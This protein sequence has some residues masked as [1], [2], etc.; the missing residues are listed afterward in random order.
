MAAVKDV[1]RRLR[2]GHSEVGE[3]SLIEVAVAVFAT[4]I[5]APTF[6]IATAVGWQ[7]LLSVTAQVTVAS[8]GGEVLS[9][10]EQQLNG[11]QPIGYCSD[12]QADPSNLSVGAATDAELVTPVGQCPEPASGPEPSSGSTWTSVSLPSPGASS[13]GSPDLTGVALVVASTTCVGFFSYDYEPVSASDG[14]LQPALGTG[15]ALQPPSLVYLWVCATNCPQGD[16]NSLWVT[17]YPSA[18]T[19]TDPACTTSTTGICQSLGW[20][21]TADTRFIGT[22][23]TPTS[24]LAYQDSTGCMAG[25]TSGQ[26]SSTQV[27]ASNLGSVQVVNVTA[28][29][30]SPGQ[31]QTSSVSVEVT[32]NVYQSESTSSA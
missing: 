30:S 31:T 8:Q 1:V 21:S 29:L 9:T 14:G 28:E 2:S 24:V 10:V 26:G 19:Y 4:V 12:P 27:S 32:G 22:L 23:A 18:G 15:G 3:T 7:Y 5:I 16:G 17:Y 13:C 20:S 25:C 11:A 6:A